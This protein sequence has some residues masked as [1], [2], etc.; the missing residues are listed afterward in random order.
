MPIDNDEWDSGKVRPL[1]DRI[2]SFLNKKD[3]VN[4]AFSLVSIMNGLGYE[5]TK[6]EKSFELA[7]QV[8]KTLDKLVEEKKI[9][10]K[11]IKETIGQ[12]PYYKAVQSTHMMG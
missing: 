1:E 2:M 5:V 12:E 6:E 8:R 3:G 9:E 4:C 10:K 7:T 11:I